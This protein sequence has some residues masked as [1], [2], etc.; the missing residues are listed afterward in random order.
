MTDDV[1]ILAVVNDNWKGIPACLQRLSRKLKG[2]IHMI[3]VEDIEPC[4]AEALI[5]LE[6]K[7]SEIREE[8]MK[9]L[10]KLEEKAKSL[11][12]NVE[13]LGV[14]C[15]IVSERVL[16]LEKQ[17]NPDIILVEFKRSFLGRLFS[18]DYVDTLLCKAETPILI[19]R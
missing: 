4:P 7:C 12:F 16:K 11:G 1:K 10:K 15:G 18:T 14:H 6:G 9:I 8:G 19:V 3:Y 17:L 5:E 2:T 13:I